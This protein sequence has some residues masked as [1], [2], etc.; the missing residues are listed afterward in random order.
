METP[1]NGRFALATSI[2]TKVSITAML[3]SEKMPPTS[4]NLCDATC[5]FFGVP[6]SKPTPPS[7]GWWW[8]PV[9]GISWQALPPLQAGQKLPGTA[10]EFLPPYCLGSKIVPWVMVCHGQESMIIPP[11]EILQLDGTCSGLDP[12]LIGGM[13]KHM[14][15]V[16]TWK[17]WHPVGK[18]AW[19]DVGHGSADPGWLRWALDATINCRV[20][21]DFH[22]VSQWFCN[23]VHILFFCSNLGAILA[24][25]E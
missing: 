13:I 11:L 5:G 21:T 7:P 14:N 1:I 18:K 17:M 15:P 10:P 24:Y 8:W 9:G 3:H 23:A 6:K 4:T 22:D 2:S 12:L 20:D 19:N 25:E 16:W